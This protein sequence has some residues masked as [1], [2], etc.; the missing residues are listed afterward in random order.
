[1]QPLSSLCVVVNHAL[2]TR[3]VGA[4]APQLHKL[5]QHKQGD[6]DRFVLSGKF[7]VHH[8]VSG[9]KTHCAET[10]NLAVYWGG[11]EPVESEPARLGRS[12]WQ[13]RRAAWCVW[14]PTHGRQECDYVVLLRPGNRLPGLWSTVCCV[15]W[16]II[17]RRQSH[18]QW[19]GISM[20]SIHWFSPAHHVDGPGARSM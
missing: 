1:M 17:L 13:G 8:V 7:A 15:G 12:S 6:R 9:L 19:D 18:K 4:S 16:W 11:P 3:P 2:A 14:R 5:T 10:L 20:S